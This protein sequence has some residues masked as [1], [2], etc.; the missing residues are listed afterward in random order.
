MRSINTVTLT[1]N[2]VRDAEIRH[3]SGGMAIVTGSI[4]VTRAKK[5]G[6]KWE[7]E[8][9]FFDVVLLGKMAEALLPKLKRGVP[10]CL[11]GSLKQDRWTDQGGGARSRVVIVVDQL[12]LMRRDDQSS[13]PTGSQSDGFEDDIPF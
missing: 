10:V 7:D 3:T 9:S 11:A 5:I 6:D 4:A 12:L 2:I 13:S 8:A 1:G